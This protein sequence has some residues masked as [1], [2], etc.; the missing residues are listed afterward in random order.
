MNFKHICQWSMLQKSQNLKSE[1][2][3]NDFGHWFESYLENTGVWYKSVESHTFSKNLSTC[4]CIGLWKRQNYEGHLG[5][6]LVQMR[7]K[8]DFITKNVYLAQLFQ[9]THETFLH[10]KASSNF[11]RILA[12]TW[13]F[14]WLCT[15]MEL[16]KQ[17]RAF[18]SNR[19]SKMDKVGKS[20]QFGHLEQFKSSDELIG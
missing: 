5:K 12:I 19:A 8:R 7:K 2:N 9:V 15:T 20:G 4:S 1:S 6:E 17:D 10:Q 11:P 3:K 14:F 13:W 18:Q 16:S